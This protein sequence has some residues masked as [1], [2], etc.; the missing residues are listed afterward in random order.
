[1]V[2]VFLIRQ[3]ILISGVGVYLTWDAI[4]KLV[5]NVFQQVCVDGTV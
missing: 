3:E 5:E 1:M 2:T 4:F